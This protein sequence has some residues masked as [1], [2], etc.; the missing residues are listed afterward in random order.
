[1]HTLKG[2]SASIGALSLHEIIKELDETKNKDLV[3]DCHSEL[4]K[5]VEELN[6]KLPDTKKEEVKK[7]KKEKI[8]DEKKEELFD[9]LK[10]AESISRPRECRAVIDE[11]EKYILS[12]D[13]LSLF[14]K[15]KESI[16]KYDFKEASG[17]LKE[18]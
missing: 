6:E 16:R 13:D 2:L 12:D 15:L 11:L 17:L 18:I 1:M 5:V 8:S 14:D 4:K 9:K 10:K 7:I 3:S